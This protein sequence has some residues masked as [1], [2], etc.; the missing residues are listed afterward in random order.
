[1]GDASEEECEDCANV[2]D[3]LDGALDHV[4]SYH[5]DVSFCWESKYPH[6]EEEEFEG[7]AVKVFLFVMRAYC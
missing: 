4:L 1:M 6:A 2:C 3:D 7:D 5:F